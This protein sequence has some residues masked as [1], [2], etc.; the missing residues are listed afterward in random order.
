MITREGAS[1]SSESPL[2]TTTFLKLV[3]SSPTSFWNTLHSYRFVQQLLVSPGYMLFFLVKVTSF[4]H[5]NDNILN[6]VVNSF[7]IHLQ[8]P[9]LGYFYDESLNSSFISLSFAIA[10]SYF[11]VTRID[12]LSIFFRERN[13]SLPR[14]E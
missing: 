9:S 1:E 14:F 5:I 11:G 6:F 3:K 7:N 8:D 10:S 2:A 12:R 4:D 13:K